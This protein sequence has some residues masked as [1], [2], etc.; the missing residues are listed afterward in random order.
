[1]AESTKPRK[2]ETELLEAAADQIIKRMLL[3][4]AYAD[5]KLQEQAS[6]QVEAEPEPE[7]EAEPEPAADA[8]TATDTAQPAEEA[9]PPETAGIDEA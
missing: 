9:E 1:M 6:P 8:R 2:K 4:D 3:I 5:R 7:A